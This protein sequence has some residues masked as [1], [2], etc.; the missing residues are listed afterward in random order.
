[1]SI[2]VLVVATLSALGAD[3]HA[4]DP[5]ANQASWRE[6]G[7]IVT[8]TYRDTGHGLSWDREVPKAVEQ[9]TSGQRGKSLRVGCP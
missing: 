2:T 6:Q 3:C 7:R 8:A 9:V 4:V 1:M 5:L